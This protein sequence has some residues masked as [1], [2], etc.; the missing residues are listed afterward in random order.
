MHGIV[1]F[2]IYNSDF[3]IRYQKELKKQLQWK[4]SENVNA[5]INVPYRVHFMFVLLDFR[6]SM[7]C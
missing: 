2:I 1:I 3:S 6:L 4:F 7:Q 5:V